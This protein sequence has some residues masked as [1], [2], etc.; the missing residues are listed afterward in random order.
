R[1]FGATGRIYHFHSIGNTDTRIFLYQDDGV[2]QLAFDDDSGDSNN[3]LL[4]YE[5]STDSYYKLRVE[6]YP[7]A[8]GAYV[9]HYSYWQNPDAYEPDDSSTTARSINI[10]GGYNTV[11]PHT[12]HTNTDQDWFR[13]FGVNTGTYHF[14]TTGNTDTRGAIY[15]DAGT[16]ALAAN[17]DNGA[18]LNF[19]LSYTI[20]DPSAYFKLRV[21]GSFGGSIGAYA[22]YYTYTA[23]PDSYESDDFAS[24]A[25]T[26]FPYANEQVQSHT[27]HNTAD[28][29]WFEFYAY[30]GN[31][32]SFYSST[33]G[34][35][36]TQVWLYQYDGTTLIASDDDGAGYP[37][38]RLDFSPTANGYYKLMVDG[39]DLFCGFYQFH[40]YTWANP[41]SYEP[42]NNAAQY[43]SLQPESY[44]QTQDHTLHNGTDED[45]FRFYGLAGRVYR[46]YSTGNMDTRIFLLAADGVTVLDSDDDD[47]DGNNFLL[48]FAPA[49][50]GYYLAMVN[51]FGFHTGAYV[52]TYRYWVPADAYEP[53]NSASQNNFI[54]LSCYGAVL[55]QNHTLHTT[56]DQDWF[57]FHGTAGLIYTISS[58]GDSDTMVSLYQDDGVTLIASDDDS[59][60]ADNFLLEFSPA[61]TAYY[62]FKVTGWSGFLGS[63]TLIFYYSAP[64][65]AYEPDNS[66]TQYTNLTVT[67]ISQSQSHSLHNASDG[68]WFRFQAFPG[69]IYSF[70]STGDCDPV[71]Y[72]Y[73]DDGSTLLASDDNSYDG[74]NFQLGFTA[75]EPSL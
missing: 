30:T 73:Q 50:S 32:Y 48:D 22:I 24:L 47:G 10:Y 20:T 49:T 11:Q 5:F 56:T 7:G 59:G 71:A 35:T 64:P 29:D 42:D 63:Y 27:L 69:R 45:W 17:D 18:N 9:L 40:Y 52:F 8:V 1:F 60:L 33:Q 6:G 23:P 16:T 74:H 34:N 3:F 67:P 28:E 62:K 38:F 51:A 13:F 14:W 43:T 12:L 2:T 31:I 72:L 53:D 26:L 44:D 25:Q 70:H 39:F 4:D 57:R 65:D 55:T 36:D 68:D 41:D 37:N 66:A 46:F 15:T 75:S 58:S 54:D 61:S 21:D 19:D